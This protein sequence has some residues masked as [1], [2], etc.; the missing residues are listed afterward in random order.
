[1][2]GLL[3]VNKPSGITSRDVV[4]R[5]QRLVRGVKVGHAGTL[6]PLATGVLV[7]ALGPATRLVE[8]VQRMPKT[9]VGTFLLGRASDTEDVEGK[10]VELENPPRPT[11][12]EI[13]AALP[14]LTGMI[15]QRPPAFSALK[16]Q[17]RRAYEV[18]RRGGAV[19]LRPRPV[20]VHRLTLVR[21]AYPELQLEVCCGSGTYIRSLGRDVAQALGTAAVMSA[22]IRT[23]IGDFRIEESCRTDDLTAET[24]RGQLLPPGRALVQ[25]PSVPLAADE[26]RRLADGVAIPNRWQLNAPELAAVD[27]QGQLIAILVPRGRDELGPLRNFPRPLS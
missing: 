9:Y 17:G 10:V 3:N 6:D 19:E 20:E 4:N 24:I 12:G 2:F 26:I 18:A 5:V 23:A 7:V 11:A 16:V 14:H 21:Y 13:E 15:E 8:Y 27:G 1:M 22:L 25:L